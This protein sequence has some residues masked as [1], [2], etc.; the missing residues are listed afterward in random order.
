MA[1]T[2]QKQRRSAPHRTTRAEIRYQGERQLELQEAQGHSFP[3][4]KWSGKL[5]R[6]ALD[7]LENLVKRTFHNVC[8]VAELRDVL[9][10]TIVSHVQQAV[11]PFVF[12]HLADHIHAFCESFLADEEYKTTYFAKL[13]ERHAPM[14]E[15]DAQAL[16]ALEDQEFGR[17]CDEDPEFEPAW[18]RMQDESFAMEIKLIEEERAARLAAKKQEW[19]DASQRYYEKRHRADPEWARKNPELAQTY[20][21]FAPVPDFYEERHEV[22][23][24][25]DDMVTYC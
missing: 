5:K 21:G 4:P 15:S 18:R 7:A 24:D 17:L 16:S 3:L 20:L 6:R 13:R 22:H 2:K 11:G 12:K 10:P 19:F 9:Q 25:D 23:I 14:C 8:S 1:R